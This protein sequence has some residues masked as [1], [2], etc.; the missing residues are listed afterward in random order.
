LSDLRATFAIKK[1]PDRGLGKVGQSVFRPDSSQQDVSV[2]EYSAVV[3]VK[4]CRS[5]ATGNDVPSGIV[6]RYFEDI[7]MGTIQAD[8]SESYTFKRA[9]WISSSEPKAG[10]KV[11]FELEKNRPVRIRVEE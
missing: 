8:D 3:G 10:M 9:D 11:T 6:L 4:N 5:S 1:E 2:G 7:K